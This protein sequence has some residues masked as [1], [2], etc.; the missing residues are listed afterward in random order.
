MAAAFTTKL[1]MIAP[2]EDDDAAPIAQSVS[3]LV[4]QRRRSPSRGSFIASVQSLRQ[5]S[6]RDLL[7]RLRSIEDP[8][9]FWVLHLELDKRDVPPCLRWPR[10]DETPQ[11]V[12][13]SW[14]AD[15]YW[16]ARRY[17]DHVPLYSRWKGL[18]V[19][20]PA[21]CQWHKTAIWVFKLRHSASYLHAK[22]L[23][24]SD[25]QRQP[26]MTMVS[27]AMRGD[28]DVIKRLPQLRDR[29]REHAADNRDKSGRVTTEDITERRV[30]LLRLFL[31]AGR[32]RTRTAEYVEL[33]GGQKISRQSVTRQ[34][35]AI[36]AAT[37]LRLLKSASHARL[38]PL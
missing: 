18:F 19:H 13:L 9:A 23:G 6:T 36:E 29:I 35:E 10:R 1:A 15:V 31:L 26:L 3:E 22:G 17:P 21:S 12:F 30:E 27:N 38:S 24:L 32:N 34:L 28:R 37:R 5:A 2:P 14:L 33:L 8:L 4:A 20:K 16:L 7:H 11:L 25:E